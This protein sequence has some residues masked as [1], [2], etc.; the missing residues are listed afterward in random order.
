M[1]RRLHK[2]H[3]MVRPL[4]RGLGVDFYQKGTL[5]L[6]IGCVAVNVPMFGTKASVRCSHQLV[7]RKTHADSLRRYV[8]VYFHKR[9]SLCYKV[10]KLLF[11]TV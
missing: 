2:F 8:N 10:V 11:R 3:Q 7:M 4:D 6:R 5:G 1:F 9:K